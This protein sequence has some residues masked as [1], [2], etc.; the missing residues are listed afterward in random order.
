M[1]LLLEPRRAGAIPVVRGLTRTAVPIGCA[2]RL[3]RG[4]AKTTE[5]HRSFEKNRY[6]R[7]SSQTRYVFCALAER[8]ISGA[9]WLVGSSD[10]CVLCVTLAVAVSYLPIRQGH[11]VT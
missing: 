7:N 6:W 4:I 11:G 10:E 3:R 8:R 5:R 2:H 1:I 9:G